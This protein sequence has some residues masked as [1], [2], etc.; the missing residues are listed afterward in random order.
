[1]FED[2]KF[3]KIDVKLLK[4]ESRPLGEGGFGAVYK[5]KYCTVLKIGCMHKNEVGI[6]ATKS[7]ETRDE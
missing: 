7:T 3:N 6:Q 4:M 1:M 5:T 2:K